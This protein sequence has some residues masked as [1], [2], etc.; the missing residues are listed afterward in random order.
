MAFHPARSDRV[1][2]IDPRGIL[3]H[4]TKVR[5]ADDQNGRRASRIAEKLNQEL[6]AHWRARAGKDF[7]DQANHYELARQHV[8]ALGL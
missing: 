6:E 2:R 8:R 7:N 3:K 5:I 1:C 4:S